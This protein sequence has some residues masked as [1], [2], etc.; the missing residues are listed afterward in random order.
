[1][2]LTK[3]ARRYKIQKAIQLTCNRVFCVKYFQ[4]GGEFSEQKAK[5][6]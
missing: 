1:M 5:V 2:N 6:L 3:Q 4:R